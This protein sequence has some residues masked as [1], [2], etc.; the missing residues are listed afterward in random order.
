[1]LSY[2]SIQSTNA[3][4]SRL[5]P[6]MSGLI[7]CCALMFS[8]FCIFSIIVI[9]VCHEMSLSLLLDPQLKNELLHASSSYQIW[10]LSQMP[11]PCC[12]VF[13]PSFPVSPP[14]SYAL[15][16][17]HSISVP[18]QSIAHCVR[19]FQQWKSHVHL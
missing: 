7:C 5:K 13:N 15:L 6:M 19:D 9:H 17:F 8:S 18:N 11:N 14:P 3:S 16:P 12:N 4:L 1:M 2:T 10:Q